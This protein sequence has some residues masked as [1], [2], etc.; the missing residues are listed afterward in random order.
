LSH[1]GI[2]AI[3][4]SV[5]AITEPRRVPVERAADPD[6]LLEMAG[7]H[8][9]GVCDVRAHR[10]A[11]TRWATVPSLWEQSTT[12]LMTGSEQTGGGRPLRER[13]PADLDLMEIRSIIKHTT[14]VELGKRGVHP[15]RDPLGQPVDFQPAELRRLA[16]LATQNPD[17]VWWWEYRFGQWS[18]LLETY[19]RAV[20]RQAKPVRLRAACP[21]CKTRQM[22]IDVDGEAMVVSPLL[23]DFH[24]GW[25]RAATCQ[26]CLA[27][28]FR[29][30]Q[31]GEL[32]GLLDTPLAGD[33]PAEAV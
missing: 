19:L 23:I 32:A 17:D 26:A 1:D 12:A 30:D 25:I 31:L 7:D 15:A 24:D 18:R 3:W 27:T 9:Y 8:T 10:A 6:W 11:T 5:D 2:I 4:A 16:S 20:E 29:G 21:L 28:W 33:T 22:T 14:R 13:S